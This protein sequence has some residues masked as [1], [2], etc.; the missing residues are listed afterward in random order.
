MR[1]SYQEIETAIHDAEKTLQL[2]G[3]TVV[4]TCSGGASI[5]GDWIELGGSRNGQPTLT[6]FAETTEGMSTTTR[7][8]LQEVVA[9]G[10]ES[11]SIDDW[12]DRRVLPSQHRMTLNAILMAAWGRTDQVTYGMM[13]DALDQIDGR[14]AI[15]RTDGGMDRPLDRIDPAMVGVAE[16]VLLKLAERNVPDRIYNTSVEQVLNDPELE[17]AATDELKR[18]TVVAGCV[19]DLPEDLRTAVAARL[20]IAMARQEAMRVYHPFIER[21]RW[22]AIANHL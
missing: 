14:G 10:T 4:V 19:R 22:A 15:Y 11:G 8:D 2:Q 9:V 13:L 7:I 17:T 16:T 3:G 21:D 5:K 12:F 20:R 1:R 6:V 18:M